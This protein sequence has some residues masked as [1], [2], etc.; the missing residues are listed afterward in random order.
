[1]KTLRIPERRSMIGR[2]MNRIAIGLVVVLAAGCASANRLREAQDS[3]NQAAAAENAMR[4][5]AKPSEAVA[6]LSAVR[7]GYASALL[8]LEKLED[9]DQRRLRDDGLWGTALTLR[10]LTQWRL[11]FFDKALASAQEAQSSA[12]D[13]MY[14]RDRAVIA[15]LPGLIKTDQAYNKILSNAPL[16]DVEALLIDGN[17]AIATIESA[18]KQVERDHPVQV[19]LLQVQ[20]A[21]YRN[22]EVA[23]DR[24]KNHATVPGNHAAR[25]QANGQLKELDRLLKAQKAG[26]AGEDLVDHWKVLCT[27]DAP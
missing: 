3:F 8:S 17:G 7:S 2:P 15:A 25:V 22:Y 14:P 27:L 6:G 4:F 12:G 1:M 13:Q 23:L 24:L 5:D 10:A 20:L 18:R 9:T 16:S 26:Q 19:Y 21:A 11:G